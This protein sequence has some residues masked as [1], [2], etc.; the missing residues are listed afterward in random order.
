MLLEVRIENLLLIERA[1]LRLGPGLNAI[2][3]ETGAG[4]TILAHSFDLLMG[5]RAK[6]GIV[7]PGASEAY[8]EGVFEVPDGLLDD[9]ELAEIA[10]RLPEGSGELVLGRRVSATGRTSAFLDGRSASA[11]DLQALSSRLLAFYGQHEHRKLTLSSAQLETLDGFAGERHLE[12]R[13]AYREAHGEVL[14]LERELERIREREGAR[15]R[16]LDLLR[17]ELDEIVAA[18]PGAEEEAELAADRERLRHAEGLRGAAA[19]ALAAVS[20]DGE[21]GGAA[22]AMGSAEAALV[23]RE[24][25]DPA[26]D[27][28]SETARGLRV[29]LQELAGELR[30]Y[31]EGVEAE[32]G[33]LEQVEERLEVIDRLKRKHGGSIE[34]V[35]AHAEHCRAEIDAIEGSGDVTER[36]EAELAKAMRTRTD[37]V[38][39]LSE[40]R[41]KSAKR[42]ERRIA[43]ELDQLGMSDAK[44]QVSLEPHPEGFGP[45]G[46]E[47]VTF[48]VATNPGMPMSPL[49]EAASGGELSRLMLALAGQGAPGGAATYVFDEIDAGVGGNTARTVG[50]RL[51][52]LGTERQVLCITHLPQVASMAE[53]HFTISKSVARGQATATVERVD[54]DDLVAEIVRM[55]GGGD[56]DE[57]ADRHA[58][59]LLKAA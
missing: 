57:A 10:E 53:A 33:R 45:L 50:E 34:S 48:R 54:G 30:G 27:G 24:G 49:R 14:R 26:L 35:L 56:G 18:Q 19:E 41:A 25:V 8:V 52:A 32:P 22:E 1:E 36:L 28:L 7:R 16:D 2:T 13:R 59:E 15:V 9:P 21:T 55:L 37:L 44:L 17:Y 47:R 40:I 38:G 58:R 11:P 42:L 23:A 46:Q 4:K 3:G 20:G 31:A 51:R 43:K 39:G 5:G 12:R 29:E 6:E